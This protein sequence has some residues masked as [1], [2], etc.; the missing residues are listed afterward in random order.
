M[1]KCWAAS[2]SRV[3]VC[4]NCA[5]EFPVESRKIDEREGE[6]QEI[7]PEMLAKRRE[8]QKQGRAQ[9]LEQLREFARMKN[10]APGWAEHVWA[11]RQAKRA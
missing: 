5:F 8:R 9:S 10:Y 11:A 7:T 1:P 6:L 3:A 4:S 2:S